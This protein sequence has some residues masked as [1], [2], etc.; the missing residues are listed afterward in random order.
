MDAIT[1]LTQTESPLSRLPAEF[2]NKVYDYGFRVE[3]I[4]FRSMRLKVAQ[5]SRD[6]ASYTVEETDTSPPSQP[7]FVLLQSRLVCRQYHAETKLLIFEISV[8]RLALSKF[9]QD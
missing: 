2:R 5:E 7:L 6:T 8:L 9:P 4:E 1:L 3:C